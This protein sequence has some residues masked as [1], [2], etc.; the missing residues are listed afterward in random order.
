MVGNGGTKEEEP[1]FLCHRGLQKAPPASGFWLTEDGEKEA[2]QKARQE[3]NLWFQLGKL[4]VAEH[5]F[6]P[7]APG[8]ALPPTLRRDGGSEVLLGLGMPTC[9]T[10]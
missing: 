9:L 6:A 2:R 7:P 4:G 8:R 10:L 5:R 3:H 1:L